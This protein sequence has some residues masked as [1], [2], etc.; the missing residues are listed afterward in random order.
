MEDSQDPFEMLRQLKEINQ[1]AI[2]SVRRMESRLRRSSTILRSTPSRI[3]P[4]ARLMH[5]NG[6]GGDRIFE[7]PVART[8]AEMPEGEAPY[9]D[10]GELLFVAPELPSP[11]FTSSDLPNKLDCN[12]QG[13]CWLGNSKDPEGWIFDNPEQCIEWDQWLPY[14]AIPLPRTKIPSK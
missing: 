1:K 4:V 8:F 9:Y 7:S 3:Q 10:E 11:T 14:W 5:W 12:V 13:K 2:E 6:K